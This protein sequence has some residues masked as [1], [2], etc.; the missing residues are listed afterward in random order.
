[1]RH[2]QFLLAFLF[3]N[4]LLICSVGNISGQKRTP[5]IVTEISP[6][7]LKIT[8]TSRKVCRQIKTVPLAAEIENISQQNVTIDKYFLWHNSVSVFL[9]KKNGGGGGWATIGDAHGAGDYLRLKPG[10]KY[11]ETYNFSLSEASDD[12]FQG[13]DSFLVRVHYQAV[14]L[15]KYSGEDVQQI[16]TE[17]IIATLKIRIVKCLKK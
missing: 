6:L 10:E 3:S 1:M 5:Q 12:F 2:Q 4:L 14:R 7:T 11:R 9:H 13:V 8:T 16:Y 15:N 17:P